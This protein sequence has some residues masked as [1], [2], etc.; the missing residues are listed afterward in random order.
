MKNRQK[1]NRSS[2][3]LNQSDVYAC[4]CMHVH[5]MQVN[6]KVYGRNAH[7]STAERERD[8]KKYKQKMECKI[9]VHAEFVS[10]S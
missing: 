8:E 6:S 1:I 9:R 2:Q 5:D 7:E 10:I 4:Q 3:R